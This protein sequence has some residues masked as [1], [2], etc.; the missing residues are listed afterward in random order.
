MMVEVRE[1]MVAM[2]V[3][4]ELSPTAGCCGEKRA[5]KRQSGQVKGQMKQ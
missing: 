5:M 1:G 2:K 4:G 3:D